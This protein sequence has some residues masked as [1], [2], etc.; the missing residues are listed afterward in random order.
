[1][2]SNLWFDHDLQDRDE[3]TFNPINLLKIRDAVSD[4]SLEVELD[5]DMFSIKYDLPKM[6]V[7]VKKT[8]AFFPCGWFSIEKLQTFNCEGEL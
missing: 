7:F 8:D 6:M 1:M 3:C 2:S 4:F 5:G